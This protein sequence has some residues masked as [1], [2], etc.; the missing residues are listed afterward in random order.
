MGIAAKGKTYIALKNKC[1]ELGITISQLCRR[2][3]V[4]RSI[5]ERWKAKDPK[6]LETLDA[7]NKALQDIKKETQKNKN[8]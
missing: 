8:E 3:D 2:A 6:T 5:P 4:D 7:L 1:D